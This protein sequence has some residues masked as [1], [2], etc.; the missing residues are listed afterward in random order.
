MALFGKKKKEDTGLDVLTEIKEPFSFA[1]FFEEQV[2]ERYKKLRKFLEEK[3]ILFFLLS[4]FQQ[5]NRLIAQLVLIVSGILI[6]IVPRSAHLIDEAKERNAASEMAAL[7]EDG[8]QIS[9]GRIQVRPLASSQY[10]KQHLLAFLITGNGGGT[11]IPS[12]ASRYTVDLFPARGVSDPEDVSYAYQVLSL[13]K[14]QR[15][16]LV[17]V[18]NREQKDETGIYNL[19][20]QVTADDIPAEEATP[21][22]VVLSNTQ[23]TNALFNG[24]GVD[25]S[26]LTNQVLNNP[27]TPIADARAK[28]EEALTDYELEAERIESLPVELTVVPTV[29]ELAAYVEEHTLYGELTDTSTA[30]DIADLAEAGELETLQYAAG[31]EY[32]GTVYRN[33]TRAATG[34]DPEAAPAEDEV[35]VSPGETT[36]TGTKGGEKAPAYTEEEELIFNELSA[37]QTRVDNVTRALTVLN[38]ANRTKYDTLDGLKLVLSQEIDVAA[39]PETGRVAAP[40]ETE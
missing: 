26:A 27:N 32:N 12:T 25:L 15:L 21:M 10:E 40:A 4:P 5:R 6:G 2:V 20:V 37:L 34:E 8:T 19:T 1:N 13:T 28:L 16:L 35:R 33:E 9:A 30:E 17:Y 38:N 39:F 7:I 23:K 11:V 14:E 3:G 31:I 24:D 36:D 29:E 22:E 18:D